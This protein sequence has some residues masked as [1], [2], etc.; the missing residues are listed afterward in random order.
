MKEAKNYWLLKSE[1]TCYSVDDWK[2]DKVTMW[3]GVRNY[4]ARNFIKDMKKGDEI[5]FYHSSCA[6]PS[7]VGVGEVVGAAYPDPTAF[8]K[9]DRHYDPKSKKESP[10]WFVVDVRY[11][12]KLKHAIPLGRIKD[13]PAFAGM[14]LIQKGSRL[15]VQP[16]AKK[17]F[18]R[19][20]S[21]GL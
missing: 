2:Q 14:K 10:T 21:L 4:Q 11:K 1:P 19:L 3:D 9:K 6:E 16:V 12:K 13:D 15:S 7:V 5:L 17:H 18:E 8:D 20:V